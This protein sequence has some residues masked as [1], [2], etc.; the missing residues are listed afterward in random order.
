MRI[1]EIRQSL[2]IIRQCLDDIGVERI[3]HG[4]NAVEDEDFGVAGAMQLMASQIGVV[5]GIQLMQ[6]IQ[7]GAAPRCWPNVCAGSEAI[8]RVGES[9][10]AAYVAGAVVA[11]V[12]ALVATGLRSTPRHE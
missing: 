8:G 2:R 5:I 10:A 3:D 6:A 4:S 1:E 9:Y 11:A 12:A 7:A